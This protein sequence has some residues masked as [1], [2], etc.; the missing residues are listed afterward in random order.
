MTPQAPSPN[1]ASAI[2]RISPERDDFTDGDHKRL[3][4]SIMD[5]L[6]AFRE[7]NQEPKLSILLSLLTNMDK[8][9]VILGVGEAKE[10]LKREPSMVEMLRNAWQA[11]SFK[12]VRQL[13]AFSHLP[14][15][16]YLTEHRLEILWPVL[17]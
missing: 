11:G 15:Q 1:T 5:G 16:N 4:E 14:V 12:E 7:F 8:R 13:G 2:P 17:L 6:S 10:L 3:D 9:L